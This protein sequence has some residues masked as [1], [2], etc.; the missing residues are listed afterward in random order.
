MIIHSL[1]SA[2]SQE[3]FCKTMPY[4]TTAALTLNISNEMKTVHG[5]VLTGLPQ[6]SSFRYD[7][8]LTDENGVRTHHIGT[9]DF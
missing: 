6:V 4:K 3:L 7:I 8:E 5:T 9:I 1:C 2:S